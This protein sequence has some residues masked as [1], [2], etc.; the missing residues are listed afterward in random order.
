MNNT[1]IITRIEESLAELSLGQAF[2]IDRVIQ[3]FKGPFSFQTHDSDIINERTLPD[4][5][6][7]LRVHHSFSREAFTKDKFEYLLEKCLVDA[8]VPARL[9]ARGNPGHDITISGQRVSLKTQANKAIKEDKLWISKF[10]ELGRGEWTD[11]PQQLEGLRQL[12]FE[13]LDGYDR[14]LSLRTL[15]RGPEW[16]YELVEIPKDLLMLAGQ[17]RLEM[18]L[19]SRQMPKPGYCYVENKNSEPLF[20]LYFDGGTERKLQI[21]NLVKRECVL[22]ARWTFSIPEETVDVDPD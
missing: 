20:Q 8:G 11:D 22:H 21:K 16:S 2:W 12:F 14:I 4:F 9:A 6:D 3:I 1:Q 18:R 13:H 19:G 15:S 5:G 7:A 10:M 17:G